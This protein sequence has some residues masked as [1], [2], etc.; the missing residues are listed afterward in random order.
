MSLPR[1]RCV[2]RRFVL[3]VHQIWLTNLDHL[4][5]G[6]IGRRMRHA[7]IDAHAIA[8]VRSQIQSIAMPMTWREGRSQVP[9]PAPVAHAISVLAPV[10]SPVMFAT[11]PVRLSASV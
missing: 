8:D 3:D 5:D 10:A 1:R 9:L 6:N 7:R 2:A 4:E 11:S